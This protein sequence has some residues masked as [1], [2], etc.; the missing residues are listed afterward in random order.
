MFV[1]SPL[2]DDTWEES[3]GS[4]L[5]LVGRRRSA[6]WAP[7]FAGG[8]VP[9][10][11]G[12]RQ[13]TRRL[14]YALCSLLEHFYESVMG[15]WT[16]TRLS[17]TA[18]TVVPGTAVPSVDRRQPSLSRVSSRRHR[19]NT[20]VTGRVSY[21]LLCML[22]VCTLGICFE[23]AGCNSVHESV[24]CSSDLNMPFRGVYRHSL[25]R[26]PVLLNSML[27]SCLPPF[28]IEP[29]NFQFASLA[30][31]DLYSTVRVVSTH[32]RRVS[33]P[34]LL[35][36]HVFDTS[37]VSSCSSLGLRDV[38]INTRFVV[39]SVDDDDLLV[40]LGTSVA[41]SS[42]EVLD[43]RSAYFEYDLKYSTCVPIPSSYVMSKIQCVCDRPKTMFSM[44][45]NFSC[46]SEFDGCVPFSSMG[47]VV[48]GFGRKGIREYDLKISCKPISAMNDGDCSAIEVSPHTYLSKTVHGVPVAGFAF[49]LKYETV[50]SDASDVRYARITSSEVPIY[51]YLLLLRF[52]DMV[53]LSSTLCLNLYTGFSPSLRLPFNIT[54]NSANRCDYAGINVSYI[55]EL[56][57]SAPLFPYHSSAVFATYGFYASVSVSPSFSNCSV[58]TIPYNITTNEFVRSSRL[59]LKQRLCYM[60]YGHSPFCNFTRVEVLPNVFVVLK[61]LEPHW[62]VRY[63]EMVLSTLTSVF[64]KLV[65][66][67]FQ[68]LLGVV[69]RN[70]IGIVG[71][72]VFRT[73][74]ALLNTS[75]LGML[76][77]GFGLKVS[78]YYFGLS[79]VCWYIWF[80][81]Q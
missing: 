15:T 36:F 58:F 67:V 50:Y 3:G 17:G 44:L 47:L 46:G 28:C 4:T 12:E 73:V 30:L 5:I 72:Y 34:L 80:L 53:R 39:Q 25:V 24:E 20:V 33:D 19:C 35:K 37:S 31:A 26:G 75:L 78:K 65:F 76:F 69:Y 70:I 60:C 10:V 27:S 38:F 18:H 81:K 43:F 68:F 2:G 49:G 14:E 29:V 42:F 62:V 21:R 74:F 23:Y 9:T 51:R 55:V 77:V 41:G 54:C 13:V 11:Y 8:L 16:K 79:V 63:V 48:Y 71:Q 61:D 7:L 57:D 6:V 22:L 32:F 59:E 52:G 40:C 45:M 66:K 64:T 56:C 1:D